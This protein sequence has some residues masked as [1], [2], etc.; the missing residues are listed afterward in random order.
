MNPQDRTAATLGLFRPPLATPAIAESFHEQLG[1]ELSQALL[2]LLVYCETVEGNPDLTAGQFQHAERIRTA[3]DA[4]VTYNTQAEGLL[5]YYRTGLA[6]AQG[7]AA[8]QVPSL[9]T[10]ARVDWEAIAMRLHGHMEPTL[11]PRAPSPLAA[12]VARFIAQ[13]DQQARL[14]LP[15]DQR[16]AVAGITSTDLGNG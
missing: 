3:L 13:P 9:S 14:L 5:D 12:R 6:T 7:I 1:H 16:R 8:E 2:P 4:L 11:P 10:A 15:L